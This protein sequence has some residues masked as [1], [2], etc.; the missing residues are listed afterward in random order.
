[1][2]ITELRSKYNDRI[3]TLVVTD[4]VN[5]GLNKLVSDARTILD[6]EDPNALEKDWASCL[7]DISGSNWDDVR[8]VIKRSL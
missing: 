4:I 6:K 7:L 1:M 3:I 8:A 2:T 5:T